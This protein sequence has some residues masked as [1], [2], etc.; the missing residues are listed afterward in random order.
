MSDGFTV[1]KGRLFKLSRDGYSNF[2][3]DG[4]FTVVDLIKLSRDGYSN[5]SRDSYS[6]FLGTVI[7]TFL[8]RAIQTFLVINT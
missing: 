4:F 7:Q 3:R 1:F 6:N 8:G 2:S 5:F